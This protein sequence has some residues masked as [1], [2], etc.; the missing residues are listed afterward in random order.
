MVGL[1]RRRRRQSGSRHLLLIAA[2]VRIVRLVVSLFL[3]GSVRLD[4]LGLLAVSV[5][6]ATAVMQLIGGMAFA[7][8]EGNNRQTG[9]GDS[10]LAEGLD[11]HGR[12]SSHLL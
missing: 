9:G 6:M 2:I 10:E 8:A 11:A 1:G 3:L 12:D 4:V 7:G 5:T